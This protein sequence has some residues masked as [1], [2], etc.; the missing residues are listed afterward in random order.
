L[1][2]NRFV[3]QR[4]PARKL[5]SN[6]IDVRSDSYA[7][8]RTNVAP[9]RLEAKELSMDH[10]GSRANLFVGQA[11]SVILPLVTVTA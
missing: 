5:G 9:D 10:S 11:I 8:P 1:V 2:V 7:D 3:C 4:D 6:K